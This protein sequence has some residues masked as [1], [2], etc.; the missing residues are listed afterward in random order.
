MGG[1]R[2]ERESFG[3]NQNLDL[4]ESQISKFAGIDI[5]SVHFYT[6]SDLVSRF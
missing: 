2:I 3:G 6:Q 1:S 4:V 5:L